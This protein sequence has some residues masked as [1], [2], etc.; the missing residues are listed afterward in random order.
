MWA[1]EAHKHAQAG[2]GATLAS[3][4]PI[5]S[6][7]GSNPREAAARAAQARAGGPPASTA[8]AKRSAPTSSPARGVV[9]RSN[10]PSSSQRT[11]DLDATEDEDEDEVDEVER[12]MEDDMLDDAAVLDEI[13]AVEEPLRKKGKFTFSSGSKTADEDPF[14]APATPPSSQRSASASL[15]QWCVLSSFP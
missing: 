15:S 8:P 12:A 10:G 2:G 14:A 3:S 7:S 9:G 11:V 5:A 1:D 4:Q 6:T 13:Q